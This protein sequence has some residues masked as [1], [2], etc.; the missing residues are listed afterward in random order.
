MLSKKERGIYTSD[1]WIVV[2]VLLMLGAKYLGIDLGHDPIAAAVNTMDPAA[3]NAAV[4]KIAHAYQSGGSTGG[5]GMTVLAVIWV[6][7]RTLIKAKNKGVAKND[8]AK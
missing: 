2:Y 3:V 8:A 6:A 4:N 1:L 5:Q 7:A